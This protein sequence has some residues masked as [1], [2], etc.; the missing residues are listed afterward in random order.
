[1]A[2]LPI[3][4]SFLK[5]YRN[6]QP[7]KCRPEDE[8]ERLLS[9]ECCPIPCGPQAIN[10]NQRLNHRNF[11]QGRRRQ[12]GI[13]ALREAHRLVSQ[14]PSQSGACP[15]KRSA[16]SFLRTAFPVLFV[17]EILFGKFADGCSWQAVANLHC[18]DHF[19]LSQ[20]VFEKLFHLLE[21]DR[22]GVGLEFYKGLGRLASICIV[23]SNYND[24]FDTWM[25]VN[26]LLY[27]AWVDVESA[28][29]QHVFGS[30]NDEA[31]SI[32]VHV[33]DVAGSKE[34]VLGHR[35]LRR[36]RTL[37]IS[38]HDVGPANANLAFFTQGN[39][40]R[41]IVHIGKLDRDA[42]DRDAA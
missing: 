12:A 17:V 24:F 40:A 2:F 33:S 41:P 38:L 23:D 4:R 36:V 25:L 3:G 21:V 37:P 31:V 35:L 32:F 39:I 28:A 34:A 16:R 14:W 8:C 9:R 22:A 10:L 30:V 18:A 11:D 5:A 27:D 19:V 15:Q 13:P 26:R 42:W 1:M 20:F 6:R 7:Q 29:K